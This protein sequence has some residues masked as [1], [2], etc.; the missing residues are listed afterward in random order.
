MSMNKQPDDHQEKVNEESVEEPLART[1]EETLAE[2][3]E[4]TLAE[5]DKEI[6]AEPAEETPAE[7]AEEGPEKPEKEAPKKK[8]LPV[9]VYILVGVGFAALVA[10][11]VLIILGTQPAVEESTSEIVTESTEPAETNAE[12]TVDP[13]LAGYGKNEANVLKTYSLRTTEPGSPDMQAIVAINDAN[14]DS[15]TN[16]E[17][18][19]YYWLEFYSFMNTY[20][21]YASFMGMDVTKP[22]AD[23]ASPLENYTWEQYFL[24]A[25]AEHYNQ[26]YALW[27][28]AVAAGMTLSEEEEKE[29]A[30]LTDPQGGFAEEAKK[31][32]FDSCDAY[33]Q[34]NFGDGVSVENYQHYLRS[35]YLATEYFADQQKEI[36]DSISDAD[37]EAYFDENADSFATQGIKKGN[38][39]AARHILIEPEHTENEDPTEEAL[40]AAEEKANEIYAQWQKDPTEENFGKLAAE[41]S[42]DPGS[43]DKGGLYDA[44]GPGQMVPE[45]DAWCFDPERQ[46]G[47]SGIVKTQFGYHIMY[48]VGQKETNHWQEPARKGLVNEKMRA[49]LDELVKEYPIQMDFTKVR[50]FDVVSKNMPQG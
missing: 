34:A 40:K 21:Q 17:F 25:A 45:F 12:I 30:D 28:K 8:K 18:Q 14:A 13:A 36:A 4:E 7:P 43:K 37:V 16:G 3:E 48:F 6:L 47:D 26:N 2:P 20:G 32:G 10:L 1:V 19:I 15:L 9:W 24:K 35:F 27:Q 39:I 31:N 41:N 29:I 33:V 50:I 22:L 42:T 44:V 49:V 38:D 5:S 23:Q 11:I 46:P